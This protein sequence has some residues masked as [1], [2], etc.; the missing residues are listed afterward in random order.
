MMELQELRELIDLAVTQIT[1]H[2]TG[3][4][5]QSGPPAGQE[6]GRLSSSI[7][8]RIGDGQDQS[9]LV[10]QAEDSLLW[11]IS[12]QMKRRPITDR[13]EMEEYSKEYFNII[14]GH[15]VADINRLTQSSL[16]FGVPSYQAGAGPLPGSEVILD[17]QGRPGA[18][19]V[20]YKH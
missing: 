12:E 5:L 2:L 10:Y 4:S 19:R 13:E 7:W 14:C 16:R 18:A 3:I 9:T 8:V 15:L 20:Q 17:Y 1:R 11:A 6:D